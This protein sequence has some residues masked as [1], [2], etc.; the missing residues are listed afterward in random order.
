M[1]RYA[2]W[3][4]ST[5]ALRILRERGWVLPEGTDGAVQRPRPS[6]P[7]AP[8]REPAL[9]ADIFPALQR[10]ATTHGWENRYTYNRIDDE[11]GSAIGDDPGLHM[12]L[13]RDEEVLFAYLLDEGMRLT[14]VQRRWI[15]ALQKTGCVE[16]YVWYPADITTITTRL[17]R[18]RKGATV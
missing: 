4:D 6:H 15:E 13:V 10:H 11:T 14:P 12:V 1:S 3:G 2:G 9:A 8:V 16:A 7:T 17:T 18:Q 5:A